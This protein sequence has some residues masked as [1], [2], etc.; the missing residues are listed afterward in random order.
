MVLGDSSL[1]WQLRV[2]GQP[3]GLPARRK[4]EFYGREL[5]VT[6]DVL[7]PRPDTEELVEVALERLP[8]G[9][10]CTVLD[11]GTGSGCIAIALARNGLQRGSPRSIFRKS[12]LELARENAARARCRGGVPAKRLVCRA[13]PA[14][15]SI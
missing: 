15:A 14:A 13:G 1:V 10:A 5:R 11:L 4:R 2:G 7:I 12:A 9:K 6:P 8:Q 3:G